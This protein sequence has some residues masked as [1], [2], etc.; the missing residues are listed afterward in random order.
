[1]IVFTCLSQDVVAH[2]LS[3]ALLNGMHIHLME[4]TNPDV[5]A[6][7][8][9]FCDLVTLLQ[10]FSLPEVLRHLLARSRGELTGQALL[11]AIATQFAEA[12]GMK[13]GLRN[14]LG[15][16]DE[17][18]VWRPKIPDPK[19]YLN[20]EEPHERGSILVGAVFDALNKIYRGRVADLLRI[21]SEGTGILAEGEAAPDLVNRL[22]AEA[23][24]T[25]QEVLEMCVRASIFPGS[26]HHLQR[27]P[28]RHHH[29]RFRPETQRPVQLPGG[30]CGG[31]PAI[32]H[33]PGGYRHALARNAA[34]AKTQGRPGRKGGPGFH[35]ERAFRGIYPL[36][37]ATRA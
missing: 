7:Q 33:L 22:A 30:V 5:M 11:G 12:I 4:P 26:R 20:L 18:G 34:L 1:M 31:L 8:E 10:H 15:V 24:E 19:E 29:R 16:V 14:A 28:A 32:R 13:Y 37:P 36:A 21:A 27:L 9:G 23:A 3:H 6:F 25:A 35:H 2:E 17:N